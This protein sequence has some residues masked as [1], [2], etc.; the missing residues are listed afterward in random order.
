MTMNTEARVDVVRTPAQVAAL[1]TILG[2]WAHP[3]DEAYLCGGLYALARAAG[4][5]VICVTATRGELGGDPTV[6]PPE[7]LAAERTR[8]LAD[9]LAVLDV[10][11]HH[12][13]E[14]PDGGCAALDPEPQIARIAALVTA[15][16]PDTVLTFGPDGGTGHA[17]HR[18]VSAWTTEAFRRAAKPGAR[19]LHSAVTEQWWAEFGALNDRW[20]A[21]DPGTPELTPSSALAVELVLDGSLLERKLAA[22]RAQAS[23]TAELEAAMGTELYARWVRDEAFVAAS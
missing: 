22:L 6:W 5:R 17:D 7:R 8:E 16:G 12:W 20:P 2:V 13:L 1:G 14:L 4:S 18:A 3:D 23:Q 10:D 11:E 9:S 21:F 19:L 15:V